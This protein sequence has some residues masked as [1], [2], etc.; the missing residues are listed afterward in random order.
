LGRASQPT[1]QMSSG[2]AKHA[3]L[4]YCNLAQEVS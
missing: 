3:K 1:Q 4:W 2:Q